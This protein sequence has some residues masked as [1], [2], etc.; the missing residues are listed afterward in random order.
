MHTR[1]YTNCDIVS[2]SPHFCFVS[3]NL[4]VNIDRFETYLFNC[5]NDKPYP[6]FTLAPWDG[7]RLHIRA[8]STGMV[9]LVITN[10]NFSR[11]QKFSN[12]YDTGKPQQLASYTPMALNRLDYRSIVW[13]FEC[14]YTL[15]HVFGR[16]GNYSETCSARYDDVS[17]I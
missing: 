10:S 11:G 9:Y 13:L 4:C 6:E 2:T 12:P 17:S 16:N 5:R 8:F 1:W 3:I 15:K 7:W 14:A